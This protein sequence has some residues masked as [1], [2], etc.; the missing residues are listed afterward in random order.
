MAFFIGVRPSVPVVVDDR[1]VR[2]VD[3][4]VA[5]RHLRERILAVDHSALQALM[6]SVR[7]PDGVHVPWPRIKP[8]K[9][10]DVFEISV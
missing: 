6:P 1:A 10:G 2:I 3:L 7:D 9:I 5:V 8:Q 4:V